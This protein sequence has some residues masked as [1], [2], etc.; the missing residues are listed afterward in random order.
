MCGLHTIGKGPDALLLSYL[1]ECLKGLV[2][3][4]KVCNR[5]AQQATLLLHVFNW[6]LEEIGKRV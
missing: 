4:S 6:F 2:T 1:L 3:I 5:L